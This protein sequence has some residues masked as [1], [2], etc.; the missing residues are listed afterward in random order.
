MNDDTLVFVLGTELA[1]NVLAPCRKQQKRDQ[2]CRLH[3]S[4]HIIVVES[5]TDAQ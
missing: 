5:G 4:Y 3:T 1:E 2:Q